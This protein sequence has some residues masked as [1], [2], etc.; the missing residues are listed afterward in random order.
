MYA[1]ITKD[2]NYVAIHYD[3]D[4]VKSYVSE[5][6]NI[7]IVK[8][9]RKNIPEGI[10]ADKFLTNYGSGYVPMEYHSV[11]NDLDEDIAYDIT[12]AIDTLS[13]VAF[14]SD[15]IGK[16]QY[17]HLIKSIEILVSELEEVSCDNISPDTLKELK[18]MSDAYKGKIDCNKED[19]T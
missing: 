12:K 14:T 7:Q 17:K 19:Q 18:E 16:K 2:M 9:K 13:R 11:A 5:C 15:N 3:L 6:S 8:V 10:L 1:A 4:V